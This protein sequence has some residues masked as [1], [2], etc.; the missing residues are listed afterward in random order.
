MKVSALPLEQGVVLHVENKVQIAILATVNA[1]LAQSGKADSGFVFDARRNLGVDGFLL[2]HAAFTLALAARIADYASGALACRASARNAEKALLIADLSTTG[3]GTARHRRFALSAARASAG[4][5]IFVPAI[6]DLFLRTE[7]CL[8][9]FQRD[10]FAKISA[11]LR[12]GT[13]PRT[14][15]A[16]Q[17]TESEEF[18][19]DVA[20][21]LEDSRIETRTCACAGCAD[22]R[23]TEA[24]VQ[25]ALLG[26]G[27]HGIRFARLFKLFFRVR[28]VR[29]A[30]G[31]VL[32]RQLAI[33]ALDLLFR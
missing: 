7:N 4:F 16:K 30:V 11:T 33:G 24:V 31:M 26:V 29:I 23:V 5:A 2:N 10:I 15:A 18:A 14:A 17:V 27:E 3:A 25:H 13:P 28:I 19:K 8:F 1:R 21:V 9:E 22:T 32:Q 20:E 12:A 6:S